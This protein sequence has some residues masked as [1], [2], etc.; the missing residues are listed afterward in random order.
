MTK[1]WEEHSQDATLEEMM[2]DS[3]AQDLCKEEEPEI[4]SYLPNLKSKDVVEL[5]AGIG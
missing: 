3:S 2:L 4:I 5:G 1:Y